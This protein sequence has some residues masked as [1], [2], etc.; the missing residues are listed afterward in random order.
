MPG[1]NV[2][3]HYIESWMDTGTGLKVVRRDKILE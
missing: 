2:G 3:T 1:I